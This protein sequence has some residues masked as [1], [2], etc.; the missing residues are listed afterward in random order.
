MGMNN[1]GSWNVKTEKPIRS[2]CIGIFS[3][4]IGHLLGQH[5]DWEKSIVEIEISM[6]QI[7]VYLGSLKNLNTYHTPH[8]L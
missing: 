2:L 7:S 4:K 3:I 5:I 1:L 6:I 8:I